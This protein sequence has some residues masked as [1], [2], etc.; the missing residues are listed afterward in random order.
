[1]SRDASG[2]FSA[3]T[4]T[5]SLSGN[6]TSVT[7]GVYTTDTGT[8]TNTML[9]GSI[10]NAKLVYSSVTLG[11]TSISLGSTASTIAGLTS[12]S[13]VS[14]ASPTSLVYCLIDGGTP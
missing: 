3:G 4:I 7:N 10:A 12:I 14:A 9:A 8:V 13:G 2:N 6:A 5:A 11:S 1:V